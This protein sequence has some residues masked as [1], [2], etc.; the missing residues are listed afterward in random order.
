MRRQLK[1]RLSLA[2]PYGRI[3]ICIKLRAAVQIIRTIIKADGNRWNRLFIQL[4]PVNKPNAA[5]LFAKAI[6][7]ARYGEGAS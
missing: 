2:N 4:Y 7:T 3:Y 6:S 1:A 5:E